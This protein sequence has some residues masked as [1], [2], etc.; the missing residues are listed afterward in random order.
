MKYTF[1][2]LLFL[3][4]SISG[5]AQIN[6]KVDIQCQILD[7]IT[8]QPLPYT[9]V[10]VVAQH[11]GTITNTDGYFKIYAIA[12]NEAL[13]I[14]FIGF[15]TLHISAGQASRKTSIYLKPK[16][17]LLN[18]V[19]IVGNATFLYDLMVKSKKTESR[20]L[21]SART[22][23]ELE[24][25]IDHQPIELLEGYYTGDYLGY[26]IKNLHLKNGRVFIKKLD[27]SYFLSTETTKAI[28]SHNQF[29]K[30][31]YFPR[32]PFELSGNKL[33][34]LYDLKLVKRY[35]DEEQKLIYVIYFRPK[36]LAD[37]YFEG[38]VWIDSATTHLKKIE[39]EIVDASR[40]PL[41][42]IHKQD[43]IKRMD[44]K[45]RKNFVTINGES[46]IKSLDFE[47]QLSYKRFQSKAF[48]VSSKAVVFAYNFDD[49]FVLPKFE[50]PD[51]LYQDYHHIFSVP[52]NAFFWENINDFDYKY[53]TEFRSSFTNDSSLI[54]N[55]STRENK[56]QLIRFQH[57]PWSLQRV[58][59]HNVRQTRD[60]EFNDIN[61]YKDD[62]YHFEIQ[63][64]LDYNRLN[65]KLKYVSAV[66]LDP[67]ESFYTFP[68]SASSNA[69]VNIYFD[70]MEIEHRMMRK[71]LDSCRNENDLERVYS[72]ELDR[73]KVSSQ[74]ILDALKHGLNKDAMLFYN[75][76][77]FEN[78]GI[79]N[80]A[81][82]EVYDN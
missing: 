41:R 22:Y 37:E 67:V 60:D 31:P 11:K 27:S 15:H 23:L 38:T 62:M 36:E 75:H 4:F 25:E 13:Q 43:S 14:S 33:R 53:Q 77:V 79:D 68:I 50:F 70:C 44:L 29:E 74:K 6:P 24:T 19:T 61:T 56:P 65:G 32:N 78:L 1:I 64:Y 35:L 30:T 49:P 54:S 63:H 66:I 52:Y 71:K 5:F 8:H 2:V 12:P 42:P 80:V 10:L 48:T 39:L 73:I 57:L 9:Q 76:Y 47:Y 51:I 7:S 16:T 81:F 17:E 26:D 18:A 46:Y 72:Q 82:F 59:I 20:K 40:Y 28:Y 34:K 3:S 58:D 21:A 45:I 55:V 69:F